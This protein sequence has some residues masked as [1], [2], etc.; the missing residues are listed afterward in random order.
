MLRFT[1]RDVLWL[2]VVVGLSVAQW[3]QHRSASYHENKASELMKMNQSLFNQGIE[4]SIE[5]SKL[6]GEI[7]ELKT[8]SESGSA[9][10][11]DP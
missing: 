4:L 10:L 2:T 7:R 5:K 1:I 8:R 3:L 6:V 9:P 11:N